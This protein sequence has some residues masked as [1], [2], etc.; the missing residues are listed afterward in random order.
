MFKTWN[1]KIACLALLACA[2]PQ[3]AQA[4]EWA[5]FST[6]EN[7]DS[8]IDLQHMCRN[9]GKYSPYVYYSTAVRNQVYVGFFMAFYDGL[10]TYL[11]LSDV[12][13]AL[14]T[15]ISYLN[16]I[17][18]FSPSSRLYLGIMGEYF[19]YTDKVVKYYRSN[20]GLHAGFETDISSKSFAF[21]AEAGPAM[22]LR[23]MT[24]QGPSEAG[25][26]SDAAMGYYLNGGLR[27]SYYISDVTAVSARFGW[28]F[29]SGKKMPI[30]IVKPNGT[31]DEKDINGV[32][33]GPFLD[34]GV[35]F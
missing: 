23:S 28:S 22:Q 12:G 10:D 5:E 4:G 16:N 11:D 20:I 29:E 33:N 13:N 15:R 34:L 31:T 9:Q 6:Q 14:Q 17:Y 18:A 25:N 1:Q 8:F 35:S 21:F 30:S 3:T 32:V 7:G 27:Y 19:S 2:L 26:A 24:I